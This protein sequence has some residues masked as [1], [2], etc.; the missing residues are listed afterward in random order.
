MSWQTTANHYIHRDPPSP[1]FFL[2]FR[3]YLPRSH[4][5]DTGN[6]CH[7]LNRKL[8]KHPH[9]YLPF[10]PVSDLRDKLSLYLRQQART[11]F[12][13]LPRRSQAQLASIGSNNNGTQLISMDL[14]HHY[15]RSHQ[16][17]KILV[18]HLYPHNWL[19]QG[20]PHTTITCLQAKMEDR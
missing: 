13:R 11:R 20:S 3:I 9:H 18:K 16:K 14:P 17:R 1:T 4:L 8:P 15:L 7:S 19:V 6:K 12:R 5:S 2:F 10:H